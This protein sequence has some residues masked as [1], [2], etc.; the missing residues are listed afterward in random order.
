MCINIKTWLSHCL[1]SPQIAMEIRSQTFH[2]DKWIT[3]AKQSR[4][5]MLYQHL[6]HRVSY[7]SYLTIRCLNTS[8][9]FSAMFIKGSNFC[10]FLFASLIDIALSNWGL[11]IKNLLANSFSSKEL[12]PFVKGGKKA[13]KVASLKGV[14]IHLHESALFFFQW[15]RKI[16][17]RCYFQSACLD[18]N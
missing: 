2:K 9:S 7:W 16:I 17:W 1:N 8:T 11:L 13:G 10:E 14:T 12:T 15:H 18:L 4:H 3:E 6:Y 5:Q